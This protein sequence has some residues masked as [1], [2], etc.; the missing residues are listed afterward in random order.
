M[1]W[2]FAPIVVTGNA[3][4]RLINAYKAKLF[5]KKNAEPILRWT[6]KIKKGNVGRKPVFGN[7][8]IS[9]VGQVDELVRHFVRGA[10]CV[11][12]ETIE[13]KLQLAKGTVGE[14]L[15]VA[16]KENAINI[17]NLPPG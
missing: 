10:P 8:D 9:A 12:S 6:C 15:G 16:W 14:L 1:K 5:G 4:R 2:D 7:L 11:L 17:D 3:E 13:T